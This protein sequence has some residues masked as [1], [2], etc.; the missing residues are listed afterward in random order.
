MNPLELLF[1]CLINTPTYMNYNTSVLVTEQVDVQI[2]I[3]I[4]WHVRNQ[5]HCI[6][7]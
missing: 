2:A 5:G 1:V 7:D 4:N 3:V 6:V